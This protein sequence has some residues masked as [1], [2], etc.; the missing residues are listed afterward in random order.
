MAKRLL[1]SLMIL[2]TILMGCKTDGDNKKNNFDVVV[3]GGGI[4]GMAAA[5][6]A[7]EQGA[8]VVL[9]EKQPK[10]GGASAAGG[11]AFGAPG[12]RV[13][14]AYPDIEDNAS[15]WEKL[16][17]LRSAQFIDTYKD[18]KY[19]NKNF[20]DYD[21][22]RWLINGSPAIID[23]LL[24]MGMTIG[25]PWT[26]SLDIIPRYHSISNPGYSQGD[27]VVRFL[28]ERGKFLGVDVRVNAKAVKVLQEAGPGSRVTGIELADGTKISANAVILAAGGFVSDTHKYGL[29]LDS[30]VFGGMDYLFG[31]G[32]DMGVDAG[33]V[34]WENPW[35]LNVGTTA[36]I[37]GLQGTEAGIQIDPT[38]TYVNSTN[39]LRQGFGGSSPG[40]GANYATVAQKEGGKLYA[41]YT[42]AF[43]ATTAAPDVLRLP[44][45]AQLATGKVKK[46]DTVAEL[47]AALGIASKAADLQK[48]IDAYNIVCDNIKAK[49]NLIVDPTNPTQAEDYSFLGVDP[50]E[51][52]AANTNPVKWSKY[53]S[54]NSTGTTRRTYRRIEPGTGYYAVEVVPLFG[55]T[56][57][58]VKT[59]LGSAAVV[60]AD[61]FVRKPGPNDP[62][63]TA[64]DR[65]VLG[66]YA[67]GENAN[68]NFFGYA[69]LSGGS[70]LQA[71]STGRAAGLSAAAYTRRLK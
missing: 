68:R 35:G 42:G 32:I 44:T 54:Y 71:I 39:N 22:V 26:Y 65:I 3:V 47:A 1:V 24:N 69:Y 13:Q 4:A 56:Y 23:W 17:R 36:A 53:G 6:S 38:K 9:V 67:A 50:F 25:K 27:G 20:P 29:D 49:L 7:A 63:V 18:G 30:R 15:E 62:P 12:S 57:G 33:G 14:K 34:L 21:A 59:L 55:G 31:E 41:L 51:V 40:V 10:V 11:A 8:K 16:W 19:Y 45:D 48:T 37:T 64:E 61:E 60:K 58:G 2:G 66:L 70:S 28:L 52:E 46:G 43:T 5:V